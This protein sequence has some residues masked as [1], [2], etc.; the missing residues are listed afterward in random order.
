MIIMGSTLKSITTQKP[1]I[2]KLAQY[3]HADNIRIFGSFARNEA[4]DES[5]VDFV[6]NFA[7]NA[8]LFDQVGL[9]DALSKLLQRK[10]DVVSERAVSPYLQEII[11]KEALPL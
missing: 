4:N 8:C 5:D 7:P 11:N 1:A 2:I 10:V 6:V 3:Y 9:I